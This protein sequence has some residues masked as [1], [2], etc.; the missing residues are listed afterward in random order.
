[1][2]IGRSGIGHHP[3]RADTGRVLGAPDR[4]DRGAHRTAVSHQAVLSLRERLGEPHL[5]EPLDQGLR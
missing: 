2:T 4:R 1:M 3:Q 5:D